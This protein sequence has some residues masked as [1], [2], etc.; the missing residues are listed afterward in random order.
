MPAYANSAKAMHD[1]MVQR[2]RLD[3][4]RTKLVLD[5]QA[6]REN[7]KELMSHWLPIETAADETTFIYIAARGVQLK[8]GVAA[9]EFGG[10][11][12]ALVPYDGSFGEGADDQR[13]QHARGTMILDD[14]FTKWIY[15]NGSRNVVVTLDCSYAA[16]MFDRAEPGVKDRSEVVTRMPRGLTFAAAASPAAAAGHGGD[17]GDYA[18]FTKHLVDVLR[19]SKNFAL[20]DLAFDEAVNRLDET[21]FL[22]DREDQF[23]QP[24]YISSSAERAWYIPE[25]RQEDHREEPQ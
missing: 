22:A 14:D 7:I 1:V 4:E 13:D 19:E 3:P 9:E 23:S 24:F 18:W 10:I 16:G 6:T 20:V 2:G 15:A 12:E 5:E 25:E 8:T 17:V 21:Y 11:D